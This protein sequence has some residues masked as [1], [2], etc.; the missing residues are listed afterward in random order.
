MLR[1]QLPKNSKHLTLLV[2]VFERKKNLFSDTLYPYMFG[3]SILAYLMLS[4]K[5]L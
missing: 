1:N 3:M 5:T 4:N 2:R